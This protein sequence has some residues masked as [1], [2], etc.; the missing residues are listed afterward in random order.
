[1]H[2]KTRHKKAVHKERGASAKSAYHGHDCFGLKSTAFFVAFFFHCR[3]YYFQSLWL[4][5]GYAYVYNVRVYAPFP[6]SSHIERVRRPSLGGRREREEK[7]YVRTRWY[8]SKPFVL[9]ARLNAK[10]R[11]SYVRV[12]IFYPLLRRPPPKLFSRFYLAATAWQDCWNGPSI[13]P[14]LVSQ[15]RGCRL[16]RSL[17]SDSDMWQ[18]KRTEQRRTK[19]ESIFVREPHCLHAEPFNA[20]THAY[21]TYINIKLL[22]DVFVIFS[23]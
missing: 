15:G 7:K 11:M 20:S 8:I 19:N 13:V 2:A 18:M 3:R 22:W 12:H 4:Y 21:R 16:W 14:R 9:R 1:M 23:L 5:Q 17:L 6:R 10:Q